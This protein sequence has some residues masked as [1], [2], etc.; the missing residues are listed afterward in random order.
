MNTSDGSIAGIIV[1]NQVKTAWKENS[2]V[3]TY[4][5][6]SSY[7]SHNTIHNFMIYPVTYTLQGFLLR[8]TYIKIAVS[9]SLPKQQPPPHRI[10]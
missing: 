4:T 3:K 9:L 8:N 5:I 10:L 1:F 7:I 6:S 2:V